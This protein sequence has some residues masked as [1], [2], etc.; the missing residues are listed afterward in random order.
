MDD[1]STVL[2]MQCSLSDDPPVRGRPEQPRVVTVDDLSLLTLTDTEGVK[3]L[4]DRYLSCEVSKEHVELFK[5]HLLQRLDSWFVAVNDVG[6]IYLTGI[7]PEFVAN[8]Q[9]IFWDRRFG[10][11]RRD[12]VQRV[13]A[14]AFAE[15]EL[16]RVSAFV[17]EVNHRLAEIELP[18]VGFKA[19]GK[20]RKA[21]REGA[22]DCDMHILGLLKEE[23]KWQPVDHLRS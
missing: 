22:V 4:I 3:E 2:E 18:K 11:N 10:A 15:F 9:C 8:F 13:L 23:V 6:L 19:E 20:L 7:V 1:D 14:T 12:M 21:W 5:Q 16:T 17:P